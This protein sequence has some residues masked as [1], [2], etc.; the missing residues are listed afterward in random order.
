MC[1]LC[2]DKIH[3]KNKKE[4]LEKFSRGEYSESDFCN[5]SVPR[6]PHC[7]TEFH[8]KL[9]DIR[10]WGTVN[11]TCPTCDGKF[12]IKTECTIDYSTERIN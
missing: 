8:V 4:A 3:E 9:E 10:M 11:E 2:N 1:K 7:A 5:D 12:I 6:Y